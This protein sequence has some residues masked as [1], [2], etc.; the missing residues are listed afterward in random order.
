MGRKQKY[1]VVEYDSG[2]FFVHGGR[3]GQIFIKEKADADL[4]VEAL[5]MAERLKTKIAQRRIEDA[6]SSLEILKDA[7]SE[8][9]G[10]SA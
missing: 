8:G 7:L 3:F 5:N 2:G 6:I 10:Y 9:A 1:E 4:I